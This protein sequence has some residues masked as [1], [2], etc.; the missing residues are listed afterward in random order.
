MNSLTPQQRADKNGKIVT[1]HVRTDSA[2]A[3]TAHIPSPVAAV[4]PVEERKRWRQLASD[5]P[6][7]EA[8][9]AVCIP[10]QKERSYVVFCTD[11][12][13]FNVMSVVR[14]ANALA[15]LTT[16]ARTKEEATSF[17]HENGLSHLV[18]DNTVIMRNAQRRKILPQHVMRFM[19]ELGDQKRSPLFMDAMESYSHPA[20]HRVK[21]DDPHF[22]SKL[23][24]DGTIRL[25]DL[26]R[27]GPHRITHAAVT[28]AYPIM[29]ALK[30][31]KQGNYRYSTDEMKD[32][33][34][35]KEIPNTYKVMELADKYG[36]DDTLRIAKYCGL[37][38]TQEVIQVVNQYGME[39]FEAPMAY[40]Q[41]VCDKSGYFFDV[42]SLGRIYESGVSADDAARSLKEGLTVTQI[43]AIGKDVE[44]PLA[45]GWL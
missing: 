5:W 24:L 4:K 31:M 30:D 21:H 9:R 18:E 43:L 36:V 2:P 15:L 39:N 32:L 16:G 33:L 10:Y 27:I 12:E 35:I 26:K 45:K 34:G 22:V 17:L 42:E 25:S 14:G 38:S 13:V 19:D 7:D 20:L 29:H 6:V 40:M 28:N 44:A 1:R 3:T 23:V 11:S 37:N 41:E 8:L